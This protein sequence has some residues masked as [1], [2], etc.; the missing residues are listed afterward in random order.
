MYRDASF[1]SEIDEVFQKVGTSSFLWWP[2]PQGKGR[3]FLTMMKVIAITIPFSYAVMEYFQ[4]A[5]PHNLFVDHHIVLT[6]ILLLALATEWM[7][8]VVALVWFGDWQGASR[9][10]R[11][12]FPLRILLN[13]IADLT[14]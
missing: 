2:Y 6:T 13:D 12:T 5:S 1:K 9:S 14:C 3:L 10:T 8:L 7:L 11:V 4:Q